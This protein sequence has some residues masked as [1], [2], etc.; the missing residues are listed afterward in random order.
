MSNANAAD[1]VDQCNQLA[2]VKCRKRWWVKSEDLSSAEKFST[3]KYRVS[4]GFDGG[5]N[6]SFL[7]VSI[8]SLISL[9]KRTNKAGLH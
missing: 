6:R 2:I 1:V 7:C 4:G 9:A 8:E 3:S 5:G